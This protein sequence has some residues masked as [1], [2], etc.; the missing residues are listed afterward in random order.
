MLED[1]MWTR[2]RKIQRQFDRL[3]GNIGTIGFGK[4]LEVGDSD[5]GNYRKAW[6][7][8]KETDTEF[9]INIE[10]PG[11][12]K[13]DIK[14]DVTDSGIEI[15]AEKKQEKKRENREKGRYSFSRSYAGFA[16]AIDLPEEAD[17][18]KVDAVYK[19]G[20]LTVH[21]TKKKIKVERGREININ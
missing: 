2:M 10:M 13:D 21:F 1:K 8:F 19:N 20:V 17:L 11:V 9:I 18:N 14:L 3:F 7:D 5:F 15:R 12:E 6:A 4:R 16:R